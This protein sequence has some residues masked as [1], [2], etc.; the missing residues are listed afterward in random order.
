VEFGIPTMCFWACHGFVQIS[1]TLMVQ[2]LS[3]V[4]RR[5]TAAAGKRWVDSPEVFFGVEF[6]IPTFW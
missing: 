2:S 3:K 1:G 5:L 4:R 6:S